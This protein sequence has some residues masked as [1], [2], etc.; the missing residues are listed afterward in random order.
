MTISIRHIAF[1]LLILLLVSCEKWYETDDVSKISYLPEFEL[2]G[3]EFI[4]V[5]RSDSG[6]YTEPGVTATVEGEQVNIRRFGNVDVTKPGAYLL[7]YY[8]ENSDG[9][10]NTAERV[11]AVTYEDVSENDLSGTYAGTLWEPLVQSK[12]TK[13]DTRGLYECEEV[14]GF[15]GASMPGRFVDIGGNELVLL[16]G[17]G[18]FGSYAASEGS[19]TS[20]TLSWTIFLLDE[21]NEGIEI[22]VTWSK[23]D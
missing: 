11:V 4:S 12:V 10:S 17:E 18:Y 22:P 19:Y 13:T 7:I 9:I 14:F 16:P 8:A 20:S 15:P 6:S 21:P 1:I 5:I 2:K 23:I 3:G